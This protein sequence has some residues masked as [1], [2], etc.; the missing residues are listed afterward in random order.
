MFRFFM[1]LLLSSWAAVAAAQWLGF[2]PALGPH[3]VG[4]H[5][6]QQYDQMR[7]YRRVQ[8][9]VTAQMM[10]TERARPVQS[11]VWYPAVGGA[12]ERLAVPMLYVGLHNRSLEEINEGGTDTSFKLL[13]RMRYSKLYIATIEF[14]KHMDFSSWALRINGDGAVDDHAREEAAQAY[15]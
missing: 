15:R 2:V 3:Q 7:V 4:L 12:P 13:N 5:V 6:R 8:D 14:M 10:Q 11:L 1:P 9:N